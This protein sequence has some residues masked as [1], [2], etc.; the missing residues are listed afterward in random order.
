M[1][2]KTVLLFGLVALLAT[3][4]GSAW[5]QNDSAGTTGFSFLKIGVG[6]RAAAL[7][8][9]HTAVS[10]AVEAP[11]WN[12]AGLLGIEQRTAT[13]ALASYLVDTQTGYIGIASPRNGRVWGFSLNYLTHGDM[14]RTDKDGSQLGTFGAYD[15]A[16][17]V[18]M[19]QRLWQDRLAL[20]VNLKTILSSIDEFSSDAYMIDLGVQTDGPL[21]GLT[22]G[23][24]LSNLGFVRSGFSEGFKDALPVHFRLGLAHRPAHTPVPML[25][26]ADLNLPNDNDPYLAFGIEAS[27]ASGFY[28]R[29]GFSM[30]QTGIQ[31]DDPLGLSVGAG[32]ALDKYILDYAYNSY[33]DLGDVHRLSLSGNF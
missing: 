33:P 6:A 12:P 32:F 11:F 19:A 27:L 14:A 29:P 26:L 18:T 21:E 16:A 31:G 28:L 30:Q 13:L 22:L 24:A 7:G 4:W 9:A 25:I 20:G 17:T 23:A 15:L 2:R 1:H 3:S 5:A 10:G 8:G